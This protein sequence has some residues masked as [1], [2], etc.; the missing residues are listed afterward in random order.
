[1][2]TLFF[3]LRKEFRQIFRDKGMLRIIII[4]PI[5]QLLVLPRAADYEIKNINIAIVDYDHSTTSQQLTNKILASG[6]FRLAGMD[7]TYEKSFNLI[8]RDKADIVLEI[9]Y[10]FDRNLVRD[11][12]QQLFLAVNAI[13][14]TKAIIGSSYLSSILMDF[15]NELRMKLIP[16]TRFNSM[17]TIDITSSNW[18][19]PNLV[20]AVFMVPGILVLLLTLIG[21]NLSAFNIVKEKEIGTIEQINVTPIKKH[22]FIL[23]KLI[24]FIIMGLVVFTLGMIIAV[25]VYGIMPVGSLLLLYLFALIYLITLVGFGLLISTYS[26][27]QVQ[28][29]SLTFFFLIIFN[30]MSGLFTSIDS[31]PHWAQ[32]ITRFIPLTYF[33]EVMRM[34]VLKGSHFTDVMYQFGILF[35]MGI[36]LNTWAVINYRKTT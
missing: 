11:N 36:V 19:N 14:G 28:A 1:M 18:Y 30:L 22:I 13:N 12:Q 33:I 34:I 17:P 2:R 8:E 9:P 23:G 4:M 16:P 20:Y 32:I 25:L 26:E 31:M 21:G 5:V 3:I 29:Q 24:P 7:N 15:N 27:T 35:I 10:G 6:Y